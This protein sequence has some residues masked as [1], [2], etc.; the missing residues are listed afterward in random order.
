MLRYSP[1][2]LTWIHSN[3]QGT[4]DIM[5]SAEDGWE[6]AERALQW[7]HQHM[8]T[9]STFVLISHSPPHDRIN[10]LSCVYWHSIKVCRASSSFI[11]RVEHFREVSARDSIPSWQGSIV[12]DHSCHYSSSHIDGLLFIEVICTPFQSTCYALRLNHTLKALWC[13]YIVQTGARL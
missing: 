6:R 7:I 9:P 11:D 3:L 2:R 8:R 13:P 12:A 1:A 10:L 5:L 4:L